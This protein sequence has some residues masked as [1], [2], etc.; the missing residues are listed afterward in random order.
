MVRVIFWINHPRNFWKIQY[1]QNAFRQF[2]PSRPPKHM[3][4]T[5]NSIQHKLSRFILVL[6][7]WKSKE[8]F[9]KLKFQVDITPRS[10]D[11][12]WSLFLPIYIG[13]EI[14]TALKNKPLPYDQSLHEGYILISKCLLLFFLHLENVSWVQCKCFFNYKICPGGVHIPQA[15]WRINL[16][17]VSK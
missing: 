8:F 6:Y 9:L 4:T 16:Y 5:T 12:P 7:R 14:L 10:Q 2:I 17:I 13:L 11:I 1:F 15:V 3:I